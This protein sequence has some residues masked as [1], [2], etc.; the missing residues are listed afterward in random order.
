MFR[1]FLLL[2]VQIYIEFL[3]RQSNILRNITP[4]ELDLY[5]KSS[6][7]QR[8]FY[9]IYSTEIIPEAVRA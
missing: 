2:K 8:C 9:H 4:M 7:G 1:F 3:I 6:A 5:D